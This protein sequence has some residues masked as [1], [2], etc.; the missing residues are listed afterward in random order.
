MLPLS[1]VLE[2]D[3]SVSVS[4]SVVP[5]AA[6]PLAAAP[7]ATRIENRKFLLISFIAPFTWPPTNTPPANVS[8]RCCYT[9]GECVSPCLQVSLQ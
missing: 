8:V 2:P 9:Q 4:L 6:A 5:H 7:H 3:V 1:V